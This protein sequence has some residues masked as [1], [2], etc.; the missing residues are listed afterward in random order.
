M[1]LTDV[2]NDFL[3]DEDS[4]DN[5]LFLN[6]DQRQGT[7]LIE[8]LK[9][10]DNLADSVLSNRDRFNVN[11][12]NESCSNARDKSFERRLSNSSVTDV[13]MS[14]ALFD[15]QVSLTVTKYNLNEPLSDDQ[16]EKGR[17]VIEK[18]MKISSKDF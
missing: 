11:P 5:A 14:A 6:E 18:H 1:K 3:Y 15:D 2:E 7:S 17:Q 8:G 10:A 4:E 16:K 12:N 9:P 13:D